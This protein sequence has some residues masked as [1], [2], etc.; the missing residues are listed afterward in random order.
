TCCGCWPVRWSGR[1]VPRRRA[2]RRA[3][4]WCEAAGTLSCSFPVWTGWSCPHDAAAAASVPSCARRHTRCVT[5]VTVCEEAAVRVVRKLAR[6]VPDALQRYFTDRCPQHA[7][8]ISYRVLFSVAPLAIVLVSI[9]GLLLQNEGIRES[10]TNSIVDWLP[11]SVTG[12][13]DVE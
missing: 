8:G 5:P 3:I 7:A 2:L 1:R 10:V 9:F 4:S 12:K 13:K 6:I 11:V